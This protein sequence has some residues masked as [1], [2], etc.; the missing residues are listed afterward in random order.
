MCE[1]VI[2]ILKQIER[3]ILKRTERERFFFCL[4]EF[5]H[6]HA[7]SLDRVMVAFL[8]R[9]GGVPRRP[10]RA[11]VRRPW[12]VGAVAGGAARPRRA[13]AAAAAGEGR[14]LDGP[15]DAHR[16]RERALQ[17]PR[18]APVVLLPAAAAVV[19]VVGRRGGLAELPGLLLAVGEDAQQQVDVSSVHGAQFLDTTRHAKAKLIVL[20]ALDQSACR[21]RLQ[22]LQAMQDRCC[23]GRFEEPSLQAGAME[24]SCM[25]SS[26]KHKRSCRGD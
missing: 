7:P 12:R 5:E 4:D 14:R 24:G 22:M 20:V 8:L 19:L 18:H 13:A 17:L 26:E 23:N 6:T 16:P 21:F 1:T 15:R 11:L 3:E 2:E 25:A 9:D 10:A